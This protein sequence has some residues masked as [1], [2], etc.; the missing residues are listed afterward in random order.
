[1]NDNFVIQIPAD[2]NFELATTVYGDPLDGHEN[3]FKARDA[4]GE[5]EDQHLRAR[6]WFSRRWVLL[7][8]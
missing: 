1:M 8:A 7:Q 6:P 4:N 3:D 5:V 2:P